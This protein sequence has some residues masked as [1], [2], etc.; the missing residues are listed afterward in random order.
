MQLQF[1]INRKNVKN[2]PKDDFSACEEFFLLVVV[3]H[4]LCAAMKELQMSSLED[5]PQSCMIPENVSELSTEE[6]NE[7]LN[8]IAENLVNELVNLSPTFQV[9]KEQPKPDEDHV[10]E[11]ARE[12]V[13]LGLL[14]M[15]YRDAIR[16][17]DGLRVLLVWK[18]MLPIFRATSRWNYSIEAFHTLANVKLLPP[19]QAHQAI[20]SRFVNLRNKPASNI[21][22]DLHNEHLNRLCKGCVKRLGANKNDKAISRYSK[23]LGPLCTVVSN[24]DSVHGYHRTSTSHTDPSSAKDRDMIIKELI[25]NAKVFNITANRCHK[26]FPKFRTNLIKK[27]D[28]KDFKKWL[29]KQAKGRSADISD[30]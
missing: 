14:Y 29:Q 25:E 27:I 16:E 19:R 22:C 7:I 2:E 11:Y 9:K 26:S 5:D 10:F 18:F 15:N 4:I 21:P 20:W 6:R 28:L 30:N 23:C 24:F 8:N 1:L 13:S 12:L 17:G 3:G